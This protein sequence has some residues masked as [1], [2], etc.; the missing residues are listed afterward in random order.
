MNKF[1][2]TPLKTVEVE[3]SFSSLL[4]LAADNDVE[5]FKQSISDLAVVNEM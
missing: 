2:A 5:G 3:H 1:M 4:E